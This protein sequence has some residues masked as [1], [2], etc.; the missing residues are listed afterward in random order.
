[1][2]LM[3]KRK[4]PLR[5]VGLTVGHTPLLGGSFKMADTIGFPLAFSMDEAEKHGCSISLPCHVADSIAAGWP[6]ERAIREV[7]EA[8]GARGQ[9]H[10]F[11]RDELNM[12]LS[13]IGRR[14]EEWTTETR[15]TLFQEQQERSKSG[16]PAAAV[17]SQAKEETRG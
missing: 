2:S 14:F 11:D 8:F 15:A 13:Y 1:M 4:Q 6:A 10:V 3:A 12:K 16:E 5:C 7:K 9:R 17:A